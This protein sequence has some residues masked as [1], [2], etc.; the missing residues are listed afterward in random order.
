MRRS[1]AFVAFVVVFVALALAW[2]IG[3]LAGALDA[4]ALADRA[5]WLRDWPPAPLAVVAIIVI[6]NLVAVP[7]MLMIVT[8]ILL[9]GPLPGAVYAYA[10]TLAGGTVVYTIGRFA[11]R[12]PVERWLARRNGRRLARFDERVARHALVAVALLRMTPIPFTLQNMMLG[13]AR[14]GYGALIG[15]TLLGLLPIF[16]LVAGLAARLDAWV[17]KP[18]LQQAAL[19]GAAVA[20]SIAGAWA[21][22]RWALRRS[23][24]S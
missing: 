21:L 16:L 17:A 5:A 1:I 10:G 20:L 13:V 24:S 2:T 12:A 14:I 18:D 9:F 22:R 4:R 8:T 6:G 3:P 23:T 7:S 19:L 15:G 11:A